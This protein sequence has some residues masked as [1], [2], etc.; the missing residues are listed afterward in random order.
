MRI[1]LTMGVMVGV[2]MSAAI[3]LA[4]YDMYRVGHGKY[5]FVQQPINLPGSLMSWGDAI[6][7]GCIAASGIV[8]WFISGRA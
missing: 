7:L 2:A 6:F 5:S 8:A 3:A 1:G 4:L